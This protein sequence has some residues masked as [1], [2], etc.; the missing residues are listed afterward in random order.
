MFCVWSFEFPGHRHQHFDAVDVWTP[1]IFYSIV[2]LFNCDYV[3]VT[4]FLAV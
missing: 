1:L 3:V 4:S 2:L